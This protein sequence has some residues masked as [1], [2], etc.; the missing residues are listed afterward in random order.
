MSP[1][2]ALVAHGWCSPRE[3]TVRPWCYTFTSWTA[4][5]TSRGKVG[6]YA[7]EPSVVAAELGEHGVFLFASAVYPD[8]KLVTE[9]PKPNVF[10]STASKFRCVKI[11]PVD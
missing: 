3:V 8:V 7:C 4:S 9:L 6:R 11:C 10:Y 2:E 1:R 5:R